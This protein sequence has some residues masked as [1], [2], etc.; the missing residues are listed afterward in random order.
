MVNKAYNIYIEGRPRH[1]HIRHNRVAI[2]VVGMDWIGNHYILNNNHGNQC[3]HNN[4][5]L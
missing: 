2:V 3:I 1:V 5:L 4:T